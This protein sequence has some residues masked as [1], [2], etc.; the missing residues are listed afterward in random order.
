MVHLKR[1]PLPADL[2]RWGR[3][4]QR[5]FGEITTERVRE[6]R[7]KCSFLRWIFKYIGAIVNMNHSGVEHLRVA[8][9]NQCA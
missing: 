8:T 9:Y 7:A 6:S 3:L 1:K 5:G 2:L 4:G